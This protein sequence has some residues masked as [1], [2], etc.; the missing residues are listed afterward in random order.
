MSVC[1]E[2]TRNL[3]RSVAATSRP[4]RL[5]VLSS[6]DQAKRAARAAR[7]CMS[8]RPGEQVQTQGGDVV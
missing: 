8:T 6:G 1:I 5:T 2:G 4:P 3:F 7:L